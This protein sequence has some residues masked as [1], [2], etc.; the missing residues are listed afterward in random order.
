[1]ELIENQV[2]TSEELSKALGIAY[3]SFRNKRNEILENLSYYYE[4]E[5][6]YSG[7]SISYKVVKKL[8]EYQPLMR[9]N[10]AAKRDEVYENAIIEVIEND[11]YQ[12]AMNVS[13]IIK[14]DKMVADLK[15]SDGTRYEYTRVR[16]RN[17]FGT[18]VGAGG[19]RGRIVDKV[20]CKPDIQK[21]IYEEISPEI[22]NE[23][24]EILANIKKDSAEHDASIVSDYASGLITRAEMIESIGERGYQ[25]LVIARKVFKQK[26][27]YYPVKVPV[28]EIS[29]FDTRD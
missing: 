23:F 15:H 25:D 9:K 2:Y 7:N 8:G 14:E 3:G 20:W 24:F 16:M 6:I 22:L 26:Y 18:V 28:Y 10:A 29:A 1:M 12:T 13:R 17:M 4:Y 11:N 21:C 5:I 19:T 27:G